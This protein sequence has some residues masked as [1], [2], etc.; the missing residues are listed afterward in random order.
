MCHEEISDVQ[1]CLFPT[2]LVWQEFPKDVRRQI[3]ELLAVMC[4]EIVDGFPS[5]EQ[6]TN[7]EPRSHSSLAP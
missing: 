1:L 2:R 6:E 3:D 7:D 5:S 4:I